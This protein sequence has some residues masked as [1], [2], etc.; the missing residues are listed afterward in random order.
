MTTNTSLNRC[1]LALALAGAALVPL[2]AL[3]APFAYVPNEKSGT[4]SVI[5]TENDTVVAEIKAGDTLIGSRM[6]VGDYK[7]RNTGL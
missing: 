4:I 5:D 1:L 2:T 7:T 3:A 6:K